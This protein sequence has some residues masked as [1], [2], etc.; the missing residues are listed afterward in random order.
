MATDLGIGL[1]L[2]HASRTCL[3]SMELGRRLQM[4]RSERRDLYYLTLLR[5]LGCTA[6]SAEAAEFVGDEVAFG[7]RRNTST[8]VIRRFSDAGCRNPSGP[9][10]TRKSAGG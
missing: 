10:V 8:T 7:A 3:L 6:G 9:I 2:E 5:M 1:P 4:S